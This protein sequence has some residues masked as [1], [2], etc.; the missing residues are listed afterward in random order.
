MRCR[1]SK[2]EGRTPE[3][4][5]VLSRFR[6]SIFG[7]RHSPGFTLLEIMVVVGIMA[8][9]LTISFPFFV[10]EKHRDSMR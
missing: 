10:R 4:V 7:L 5:G 2:V 3:R 6:P 1:K 9:I 8:V